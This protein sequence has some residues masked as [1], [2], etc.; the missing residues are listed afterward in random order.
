[1]ILHHA[2]PRVSLLACLA[3][4][5]CVFPRRAAE[6]CENPP[7]DVQRAGVRRAVV[8]DSGLNAR[9]LAALV[10]WVGGRALAPA[11]V[12]EAVVSV[13]DDRDPMTIRTTLAGIGAPLAH[14]ATLVTVRA[15]RL[16]Y[17]PSRDTLTLRPGY[18]DTLGFG[19]WQERPCLGRVT[20]D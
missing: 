8:S 17:I 1:M 16:G 3:V 13:S 11:M 18:V 10:V 2:L 12:N 6:T 19:L 5:G 15:R 7:A 20:V 14:R 9:G 4:A